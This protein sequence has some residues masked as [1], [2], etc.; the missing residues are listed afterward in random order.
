MRDTC[1]Q[2]S[3]FLCYI[4]SRRMPYRSIA[5]QFCLQI[6]YS[7]VDRRAQH[8]LAQYCKEKNIALLTY[9]TLGGGLLSERYLGR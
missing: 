5:D 8:G 4:M 7:I 2:P 9:G 3:G 1:W 6:Q